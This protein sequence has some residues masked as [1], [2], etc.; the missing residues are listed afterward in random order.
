[1]TA[2]GRAGAHTWSRLLLV[3]TILVVATAYAMYPSVIAAAARAAGHDDLAPPAVMYV[4]PL[5]ALTFSV[6]GLVILRHGSHPIGWLLHGIGLCFACS[7]VGSALS[8]YVEVDR[9]EPGVAARLPIV[10]SMF[11]GIA[12]VVLMTVFLPLLFPT[13]RPPSRRW[14]WVAGVGATGLVYAFVAVTI[15]AATRSLADIL[16]DNAVY[17]T[18]LVVTIVT[19]AVG[20][21]CSAVVRFRRADGIERR[22]LMWVSA[23]LV[24]VGVMVAAAL[25]P[26]SGDVLTTTPAQLVVVA[27]WGTIPVSIGIAITRY[28]LYHIDRIVSRTVT[29]ALVALIVGAVYAAVI[30]SIT[31][32]V[33]P[34]SDLAVAASTLAAAAVV[35]PARR[36]IQHAA[37]RRFNRTRYDG[38]RE[39]D[40]FAQQLRGQFELAAL[41]DDLARVVNR[42]LQ[43]STLLLWLRTPR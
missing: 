35:N 17:G 2:G 26:L 29:Y 43:P 42:T 21:T 13:G 25:T 4:V 1:M 22:Q 36:R 18:V 28:H 6:T 33:G 10:W 3:V 8:V 27:A 24:L 20:A 37:D 38:Q 30:L 39:L 19:G 5:L 16:P 9:W 40:A 31:A 14:W 41:S 23:A 15:L 34:R 7:M 12:A 32:T 11:G